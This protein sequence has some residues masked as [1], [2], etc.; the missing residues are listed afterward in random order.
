MDNAAM[1]KRKKTAAE[2]APHWSTYAAKRLESRSPEPEWAARQRADAV[3]AARE[4]YAKDPQAYRQSIE[5]QREGLQ[6]ELERGVKDRTILCAA[7]DP[8]LEPLQHMLD[9][10]C[11]QNAA[12]LPHSPR[13]LVHTYDSFEPQSL[14]QGLYASVTTTQYIQTNPYTVEYAKTHP[15]HFRA[16]VSHELA[17]MVNGDLSTESIIRA[18]TEFPNHH[19]EV[20]A[21]RLGAILFG[22]PQ[23][24]ARLT[25]E[26]IMQTWPYA[27]HEST[28]LYLSPNAQVRMLNKWVKILQDQQ[29]LNPDGTVILPRALEVFAKS[30]QFTGSLARIDTGVQGL[31]V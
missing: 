26:M 14:D 3:R 15:R 24:Y 5:A 8:S 1:L 13:L 6:S 11:R 31:S 28:A 25:E 9:E 21:D 30:R 23:E 7:T 17:H 10:L 2:I 4:E 27:R 19:N 12:L 16:I 20:L 22:N 18:E 29:A